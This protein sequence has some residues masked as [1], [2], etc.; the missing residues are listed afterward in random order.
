[1]H[2]SGTFKWNDGRVYEG[3]FSNDRKSGYGVLTWP[4]GRKYEGDWKL[5]KQHGKA[6][7]CSEPD[8][9]GKCLVGIYFCGT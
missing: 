7:A 1:M 9:E 5:G 2:G 4:D 6:V 8:A 3:E